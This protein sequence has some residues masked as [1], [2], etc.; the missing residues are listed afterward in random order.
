MVACY[1]KAKE[2]DLIGSKELRLIEALQ[3]N[4]AHV[5]RRIE[6]NDRV[7]GCIVYE[8]ITTVDVEQRSRV[9]LIIDGI[10]LGDLALEEANAIKAA[11]DGRTRKR[12]YHKPV[13]ID[14][15][16]NILGPTYA[17]DCAD[18]HER[19]TTRD[20]SSFIWDSEC[21]GKLALKKHLF[22]RDNYAMCA[23]MPPKYIH[24]CSECGKRVYDTCADLTSSEAGNHY[25]DPCPSKPE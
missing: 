25:T 12:N 24:T 15:V 7:P 10:E 19:I 18:C 2:I 13:L 17:F 20:R 23:S 21:P 6:T 11:V 5:R 1:C 16:N 8:V 22:V 9:E 4:R 14:P 3:A